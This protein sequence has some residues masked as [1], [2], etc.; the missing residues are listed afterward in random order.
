MKRS[1]Q[2]SRRIRLLCMLMATLLCS[3]ACSHQVG[4]LGLADNAKA[5]LSVKQAST[6]PAYEF[7]V[8]HS[9]HFGLI[10]MRQILVQPSQRSLG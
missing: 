4:A 3:A 2:P 9:S 6:L 8:T 10:P 5:E 7:A 1:P